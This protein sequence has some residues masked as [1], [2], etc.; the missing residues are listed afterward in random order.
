MRVPGEIQIHLLSTGTVQLAVAN[1][2]ASNMMTGFTTV[3][4]N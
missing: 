2:E 4:S 1:D 3:N